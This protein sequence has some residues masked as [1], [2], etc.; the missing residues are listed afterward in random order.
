MGRGNMPVEMDRP[1]HM[2]FLSFT[3]IMTLIINYLPFLSLVFVS[4]MMK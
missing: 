3:D 1:L 4:H 2:D